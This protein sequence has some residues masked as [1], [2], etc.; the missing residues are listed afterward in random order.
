MLSRSSSY[1]L[2][3]MSVADTSVLICIVLLEFSL[4]HLQPEPFWSHAPWCSLRDIFN[5][6]A[7]NTSTWLVVVFTGRRTATLWA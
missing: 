2:M 3:A 6:G 5:Y 1:Y 7:S 4:K